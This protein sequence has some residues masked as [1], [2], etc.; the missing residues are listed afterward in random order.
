M[1]KGNCS[2]QEERDCRCRHCNIIRAAWEGG[3]VRGSES[4]GW[5][6]DQ[7]LEWMGIRH[8]EQDIGLS[9]KR[10]FLNFYKKGVKTKSLI[11]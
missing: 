6:P 1:H 5:L 8:H 4:K 7:G 11:A 3:G 9:S 10:G 2:K